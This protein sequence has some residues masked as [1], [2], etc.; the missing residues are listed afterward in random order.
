[1]WIIRESKTATKTLSKAPVSVR[2]K[3]DAWLEIVKLQGP[4]GLREVKSFH[5]EAVSGQPGLHSCRLNIQYRVFYRVDKDVV[6]IYVIDVNLHDY[7]K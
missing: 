6:T 1:M 2:K 7:G 4:Q 3:Y 5:D